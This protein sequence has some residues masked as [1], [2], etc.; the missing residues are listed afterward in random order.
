VQLSDGSLYCVYRTVDGFLCS[1]SSD[2]GGRTWSGPEYARYSPDGRRIKNPRG[3]AFIRKFS[4]GRYLLL[5]YNHGGR[6]STAQPVLAGRGHREGR[7]HPLVGAE[8]CLYDDEPNTRIGYP[9][10]IEQDGR[11][12]ITETNKSVARIHE[13]DATLIHGLW[14]QHHANRVAREGLVL[15]VKQPGDRVDWPRLPSLGDGGGLTVD[16]WLKPDDLPA[17][18]ALLDTRGDGEGRLTLQ[19]AENGLLRLEMS[20]GRP[21]MPAGLTRAC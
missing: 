14:E 10:Y 8:I 6:T 19:L 16:F 17:R 5:Y 13:I 4:N 20:T 11:F 1:A 9:D 15:H 12:W 18:R 21:P 3:P 2:D 7:R